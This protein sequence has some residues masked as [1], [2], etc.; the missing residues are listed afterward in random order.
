M[1]AYRARANETGPKAHIVWV[2]GAAL[3]TC[4]WAGAHAQASSQ[5]APEQSGAPGAA[6]Q[7]PEVT[8]SG[9]REEE[10]LVE[11]P[12]SIG[13]IRGDVVDEV[14]PTHPSQIVGQ[15]PG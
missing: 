3:I 15:V 12:A 5:T 8:V 1:K 10:L 7:L 9:T 14:K 4:V 6:T 2:T 13:V 11:T